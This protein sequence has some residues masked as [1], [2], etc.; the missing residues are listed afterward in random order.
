MDQPAPL[1]VLQPGQPAPSSTYQLQG[2]QLARKGGRCTERILQPG[3]RDCRLLRARAG[4]GRPWRAAD[5]A[6]AVVV[7]VRAG[8]ALAALGAVLAVARVAAELLALAVRR[9]VRPQAGEA[10]VVP[11]VRATGSGADVVA[12]VAAVVRDGHLAVGARLGGLA[13]VVLRLLVLAGPLGPRLGARHALVVRRPALPA[14]DV[15]AVDALHLG[16]LHLAQRARAAAIAAIHA[17]RNGDQRLDRDALD[18]L[19]LFHRVHDGV[20]LVAN[21][22]LEAAVLDTRLAF[23]RVQRTPQR[24]LAGNVTQRHL[25]VL[26]HARLAERV[27][28][29]GH[30]E[31]GVAGHRLQAQRAVVAALHDD[32]R[33]RLPAGHADFAMGV[34]ECGRALLAQEHVCARHVQHGQRLRQAHR[35]AAGTELDDR[36]GGLRNGHVEGD[37]G[38][39]GVPPRGL[40]AQVPHVERLAA[41]VLLDDDA[42][43]A[44]LERPAPRILGAAVLGAQHDEVADLQRKRA[45]RLLARPAAAAMLAEQPAAGPVPL[46]D[47]SPVRT[48]DAIRAL[49]RRAPAA[50]FRA[51]P[52]AAMRAARGTRAAQVVVTARPTAEAARAVVGAAHV[53]VVSHAAEGGEAV[54]VCRDREPHVLRDVDEVVLIGHDTIRVARAAVVPAHRHPA[55]ALL[56]HN[57][58]GTLAVLVT[59]APVGAAYN[60]S[61]DDD[62]RRRDDL[63]PRGTHRRRC[64][65]QGTLV[66]PPCGAAGGGDAVWLRAAIVGQ[67]ATDLAGP[68]R[69]VGGVGVLLVV[70]RE[71]HRRAYREAGCGRGGAP[72]LGSNGAACILGLGL[73]PVAPGAAQIRAAAGPVHARADAARVLAERPVAAGLERAPLHLVVAAEDARVPARVDA[74]SA[75][76]PVAGP[77]PIRH[78]AC[79]VALL[80]HV[81]APRVPGRD[82][83]E[84]VLQ[85]HCM[86]RGR[87]P[88]RHGPQRLAAIPPRR[89][90]GRKHTERLR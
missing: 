77:A 84:L 12:R 42:D 64:R 22:R 60:P 13:D 15:L 31:E 80:A 46:R 69:T 14:Q 55:L 26:D 35:A 62:I 75:G 85:V 87:H 49:C 7:A 41:L 79:V 6:A 59:P 52:L 82:K 30:A 45:D 21:Q 73:G 66:V 28:A 65:H 34:A 29:R 71:D 2:T 54:R 25:D 20:G 70:G 33:R 39:C 38:L 11:A 4:A 37:N 86:V 8:V 36:R 88:R 9:L 10:E 19:M 81:A 5:A 67:D 53:A 17:L 44:R 3:G 56:R 24:E 43:V 89:A 63:A 1:S 27:A 78:D 90:V 32:R 57:D 40:E 76:V 58:A 61:T 18:V 16:A 48:G 74:T 51:T 23:L 72:L 68:Q 83:R 50:A 47:R